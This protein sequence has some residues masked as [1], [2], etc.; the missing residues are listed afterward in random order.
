MSADN[1]KPL[2]WMYWQLL[3]QLCCCCHGIWTDCIGCWI[4][5]SLLLGT[6]G[7]TSTID[8][9]DRIYW[10][11]GCRLR[12]IMEK[13]RL[14]AAV[15]WLIAETV[16]SFR[17]VLVQIFFCLY[18]S[19]YMHFICCNL[20]WQQP[21]FGQSTGQADHTSERNNP[22][23]LGETEGGKRAEGN[24]GRDRRRRDYALFCNGRVRISR[25]SSTEISDWF[26]DNRRLTDAVGLVWRVLHVTTSFISTSL[27]LLMVLVMFSIICLLRSGVEF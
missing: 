4:K 6:Y 1:S 24:L 18:K 12:A 11:L 20:D 16:V 14:R 19:A 5:V 21:I 8:P 13:K 23:Q 17:C 26:K 2:W 15:L 27:P 7:L 22:N 10:P 25:R 9:W 3:C